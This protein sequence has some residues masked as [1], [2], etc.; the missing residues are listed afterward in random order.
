MVLVSLPVEPV[1]LSDLNA[2]GT[3]GGNLKH[4]TLP[5]IRNTN[6]LY[7]NGSADFVSGGAILSSQGL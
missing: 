4:N 6:A 5:Q 2:V 3:Y 7:R 1:G